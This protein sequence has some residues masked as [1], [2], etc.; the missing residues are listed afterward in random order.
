MLRAAL[1]LGAALAATE[2]GAKELVLSQKFSNVDYVSAACGGL[3]TWPDPTP[4][5]PGVRLGSQTGSIS[6]TGIPS[7]STITKALLYWHGD[8]ADVH[9]EDSP[10]ASV[11]FNGQVVAGAAVSDPSIV[12]LSFSSPNGHTEEDGYSVGSYSQSFVADVTSLVAGSGDYTLA[13]FVPAY[14]NVN[15]ASLLVI[16]D[17]RNSANNVDVTIYHGNDS[18]SP[19]QNGFDGPGWNLNLGLLTV[20]TAG[21]VRVEFHVSDGQDY[22]DGALTVNGIQANVGGPAD[23]PGTYYEFAGSAPFNNPLFDGG[24]WLGSMWEVKTYDITPYLAAPG[25]ASSMYVNHAFAFDEYS[26]VAA[27]L[28][29]PVGTVRPPPVPN[30]LPTVVCPPPITVSMQNLSTG[31]QVSLVAS[32]VDVDGDPISLQWKINGQVPAV[33]TVTLPAGGGSD[34][35]VYNFSAQDT[36]NVRIDVTVFDKEGSPVTCQSTVTL[37]E[38]K[39]PPVVIPSTPS[40]VLPTGT[41]TLPDLSTYL[42]LSDNITQNPNLVV[43]QNP[44]AG[45]TLPV[46]NTVVTITVVDEAGNQTVLSMTVTVTS[47]VPPPPPSGCSLYPIALH[48]NVLRNVA[49]GTIVQ[50]IYNGCGSGNFGWLTWAGSPSEPTLVQSLTVPGDSGTYVNPRNPA[51]HCVSVGDWVQ[52]KPGIANSSAVRARLDILKNYDITV[53]VYD[54]ASGTGNNSL[55]RVVNFAM[56]RITDYRLPGQNRISAKFLGYV[57]CGCPDAPQPPP[58][59]DHCEHHENS[60]HGHDCPHG[61]IH[62]RCYDCDRDHDRCRDRDHDRD[63]GDGHDYDRDGSR[64]GDRD[65]NRSGDRCNG[66]P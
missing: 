10:I 37:I 4:G 59:G 23:D 62:D 5:H 22:A 58:S 40:V 8:A 41:S 48:A 28:I 35:L 11:T 25:Q 60:G 63:R 57:Q 47:I 66:R 38:D 54:T 43:T 20:P 39:V 3:R 45:T 16:Y 27:V 14:L 55:Y 7:G 56:V 46:G 13:G 32:A 17:D 36:A 61:R 18:V 21:S 53:P 15:G 42:G 12:G 33:R 49:A 9:R 65:R 50:N 31:K 44:P 64:D 30:T 1:A 34:T 19:Y 24:Y 26:L 52:G 2:V 29:T 6:L 51:D